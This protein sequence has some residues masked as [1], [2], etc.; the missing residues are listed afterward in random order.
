MAKTKTRAVSDV[1][2]FSIALLWIFAL[3]MI[4]FGLGLGQPSFSALAAAVGVFGSATIIITAVRRG[5]RQ[6]TTGKAEVISASE[7]PANASVEGRCEMELMVELPGK[8]VGDRVRYT[9]KTFDLRVPL[10]RWPWPGQ[11]LP[12]RVATTDPTKIEV[13]WTKVH[14]ER[15]MAAVAD[16]QD[17]YGGAAASTVVPEQATGEPEPPPTPLFAAT[18]PLTPPRKP[19]PR[20]T[21]PAEP[22]RDAD[23]DAGS[24]AVLMDPNEVDNPPDVDDDP[25][26]WTVIPLA[27]PGYERDAAAS[28]GLFEAYLR[29]ARLGE[30]GPIGPEQDQ[31]VIL[32]V[33]AL[34]RAVDFYRDHFGF[35]V[36]DG[37]DTMA[38]L[39][40]RGVYL[41]LRQ[42]T[43]ASRIEPRRLFLRIDVANLEYRYGQLRAAQVAF[44]HPPWKVARAGNLVLWAVTCRDPDGYGLALTEWV[45]TASE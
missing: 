19:S 30:P 18:P 6:W 22:V 33:A 7:P 39:E 3:F 4:A 10:D 12:V 41:D 24:V 38:S 29:T 13:L 31:A 36:V 2:G 20:P 11:R 28:V 43:L 16:L 44:D 15:E 14:T 35:E 23:P 45:P 8:D 40:R 32:R 9:Q 37:N 42:V 27:E 17:E 25:N 34:S 26:S 1:R 5:E 21:R